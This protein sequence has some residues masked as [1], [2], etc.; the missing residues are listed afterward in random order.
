MV[1][2]HAEVFEVSFCFTNGVVRAEVVL[3][4]GYEV[5]VVVKPGWLVVRGEGWFEPVQGGAGQVQEYV[6]YLGT[7]GV[8][9][10]RA[11]SE[12]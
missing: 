6:G 5:G 8:K 3:E 9:S 11:V 4:F 1:V 2:A 12:V 10:V 7:V